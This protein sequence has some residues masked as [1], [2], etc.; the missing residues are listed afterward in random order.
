MAKIC[1]LTDRLPSDPDPFSYL[2]WNQFRI[3]AESQHD[4]LVVCNS[5]PP[6]DEKWRHPRLQFIEP[7]RSWSVRHLPRFIQVLASHKP[8]ILHWI[9]PQQSRFNHLQWVTPAIASLKK[10]PLLAMSLWNPIVWE[11]S[12]VISGT[13]RTMD[14]L[15]VTH[16]M[17][18]EILWQRWPQMISRVMVAPL[19]FDD[20]L[21][22]SHW[23]TT[24]AQEFDFVPA[25]LS[26]VSHLPEAVEALSK[27]LSNNEERKAVIPMAC[28][29]ERFLVLEAL[30]DF[31][32]DARV[33]VFEHLDWPTWNELFLPL[34]PNPR[35]FTPAASPY[36]S[37]A[38]QWARAH[39]KSIVLTEEQ[40]VLMNEVNWQDAGNFMGELTRPLSKNEKS[41]Y[42][43]KT[44]LVGFGSSVRPTH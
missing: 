4:V 34:P 17:H 7:F 24:W 25:D 20:R 16:P 29:E 23:V 21:K 19:L 42:T 38:M 40:Q 44:H 11:R 35:R 8:D 31:E 41:E 1:F 30:R 13:M 33:A 39:S 9:E 10:R 6:D 43:K 37:L 27:A 32:L 3:L 15:F 26:D 12:W 14:L 5:A 36:L 28:R 2:M 18:R 22:S